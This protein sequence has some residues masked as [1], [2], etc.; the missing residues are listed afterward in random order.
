MPMA[1]PLT[2]FGFACRVERLDLREELDAQQTAELA[3]LFE[4]PLG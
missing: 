2:S 3:E 1:V 4:R